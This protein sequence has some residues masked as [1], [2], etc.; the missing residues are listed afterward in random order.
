MILRK[1]SGNSQVGW[2][3]GVF[4]LDSQ[5]NP[6]IWLFPRGFLIFSVFTGLKILKIVVLS[7]NS[8]KSSSLQ[9]RGSLRRNQKRT[10]FAPHPPQLRGKFQAKRNSAV[11]PNAVRNPYRT[12]LT[13]ISTGILQ[14]LPSST[15]S[16]ILRWKLSCLESESISSRMEDLR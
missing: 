15:S 10:P 9:N 7:L 1:L 12:A 16:L 11:I 13:M 8:L 5:E 6:G 4:R 3:F 2:F 14:P